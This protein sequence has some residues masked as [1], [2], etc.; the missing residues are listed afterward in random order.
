MFSFMREELLALVWA[1]RQSGIYMPIPSI[2][3]GEKV[4]EAG[5]LSHA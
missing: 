5:S 4:G 2:A 3:D 1:L